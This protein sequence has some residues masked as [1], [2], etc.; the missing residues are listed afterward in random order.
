[1]KF[2]RCPIFTTGVNWSGIS[3]VVATLTRHLVT[4][5]VL[6]T[7][8][9]ILGIQR[10]KILQ[11]SENEMTDIYFNLWLLIDAST[12]ESESSLTLIDELKT[13]R[14]IGVNLYNVDLK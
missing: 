8:M 2:P 9:T 13:L 12:S 10:T 3:L 5:S 14:D 1:M 4:C 7:P 11:L 6:T